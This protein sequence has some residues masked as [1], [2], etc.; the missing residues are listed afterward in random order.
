[1]KYLKKFNKQAMKANAKGYALDYFDAMQLVE[2][3]LRDK[4]GVSNAK[5]SADSAPHSSMKSLT[6][7]LF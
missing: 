2:A 7:V 4:Y 1:M 5:F 6:S 3:V